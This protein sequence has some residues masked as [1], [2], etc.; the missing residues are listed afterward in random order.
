[1]T[2]LC[3]EGRFF[4]WLNKTQCNEKK[5]FNA[6]FVA[7]F[8]NQLDEWFDSATDLDELIETIDHHH[9]FLDDAKKDA[10]RI[11]YQR[12]NQIPKQTKRTAS[13][14]GLD[15]KTVYNYTKNDT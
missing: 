5:D 15:P 9:F 13:F 14:C 4:V 10:V 6:A 7:W 2:A 8:N 3:E 11:F 12:L 1:M